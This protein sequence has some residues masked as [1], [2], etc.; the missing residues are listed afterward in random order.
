MS[1]KNWEEFKKQ[2]PTIAQAKGFMD[3]MRSNIRS[4]KKTHH[5]FGKSG[6]LIS[7]ET[8]EKWTKNETLLLTKYIDLPIT[9]LLEYLPRRSKASIAAKRSD[10]IKS[11]TGQKQ[12]RYVAKG[13][14][15]YSPKMVAEI[16]VT[17]FEQAKLTYGISKRHYIRLKR[18]LGIF[19]S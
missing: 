17:D 7:Q 11:Q 14:S 4:D 8:Y 3:N 2:H 18:S 6:Q 10:I 13:Y 16:I 9:K 12:S 1:E 5:R 15:K 19:P